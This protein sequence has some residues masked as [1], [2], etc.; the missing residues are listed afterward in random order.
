M[1]DASKRL[2]HMAERYAQVA[3]EVLGDDLV[4][5]VLFGSVARGEARPDS[6]IDLIVVVNDLPP[7][8]FARKERLEPVRARL[9]PAIQEAQG[10]G[11]WTGWTEVILT[12]EE[13]AQARPLYLDLTREAVLLHDPSGFF[14]Q[15][16]EALRARLQELGAH[17]VRS[18]EGWYWDLK[19]DFQPGEE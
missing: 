9:E 8:R 2:R 5:V 6:D 11:V 13:A 15:I 16:L 17:Y 12:P 7:A 3:G 14:R 18:A 19:P 4:S 10:Q 1:D